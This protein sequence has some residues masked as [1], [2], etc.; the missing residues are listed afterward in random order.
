MLSIDHT[1]PT[2]KKVLSYVA[3]NVS[4]ETGFDIYI[5]LIDSSTI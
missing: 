5:Q 2:L 1:L 3:L 4:F